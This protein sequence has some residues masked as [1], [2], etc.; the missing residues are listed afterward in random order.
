MIIL[1]CLPNFLCKYSSFKKSRYL[2]TYKKKLTWLPT[3][4]I[5]SEKCYVFI[6]NL[7]NSLLFIWNRKYFFSTPHYSALLTLNANKVINN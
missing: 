5:F 3:R 7:T 6:P 4:N 1:T 2:N